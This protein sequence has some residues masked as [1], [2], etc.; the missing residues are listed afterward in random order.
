[1]ETYN[2]F[3]PTPLDGHI[4]VDDQENWLVVPVSQTRDSETLEQSNFASAVKLLSDTDDDNYQIHRFGHWG[5]G[6][7]EIILV[8]PNS[9]SCEIAESIESSL[10]DYPILD[11]TDWSEREF[12]QACELW[13]IYD[14]SERVELCQRADVS[15]F[16]AR[17]D[18]FPDGVQE[19]LNCN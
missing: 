2:K 16:S 8:K 9:P 18:S 6:W 4:T 19:Y 13:T 17:H 5:P 11:E 1:M 7:F 10:E 12:K 3:S 14:I 15:I